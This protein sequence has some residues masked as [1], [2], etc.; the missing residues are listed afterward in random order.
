MKKRFLLFALSLLWL[1]SCSELLENHLD[2]TAQENYE[3]PYRGLYTGS[4]TGHES[5]T[6]KMEVMKSGY[7]S[8]TRISANGTETGDMAGMVRNDGA[9]QSVGLPSGFVLHGNLITQSGTWKS[10]TQTGQWTVQKQ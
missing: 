8:L 6:L 3:S 5:G 10:G 1:H 4:Y 7:I 9:L 2:R